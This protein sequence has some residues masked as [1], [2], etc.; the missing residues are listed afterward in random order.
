MRAFRRVMIAFAFT[1][2]ITG[3]IIG[4]V[5]LGLDVGLSRQISSVLLLVGLCD[6]LVLR[7]WDRLFRA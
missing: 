1:T 5:P 6:T 4:L 2:V 3:A 7:Y